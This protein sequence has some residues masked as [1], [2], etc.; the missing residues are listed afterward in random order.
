MVAETSA[1]RGTDGLAFRLL[2]SHLEAV[3]CLFCDPAIKMMY[4]D[5]PHAPVA[6][7]L[8]QEPSTFRWFA[9]QLS[10]AG[11][12][13]VGAASTPTSIVLHPIS[14]HSFDRQEG[15]AASEPILEP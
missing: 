13:G 1:R 6:L 10:E 12:D 5:C 11:A 2:A 3:L 15:P 7:T 4:T 9:F 14:Q 8:G